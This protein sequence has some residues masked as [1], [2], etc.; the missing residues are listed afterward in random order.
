MLSEK[1]NSAKSFNAE[2]FVKAKFMFYSQVLFEINWVNQI[3]QDYLDDFHHELIPKTYQGG[4]KPTWFV[5]EMMEK[6]EREELRK[7][8]NEKGKFL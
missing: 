6:D 8:L 4:R 3:L 5:K 1:V 7:N 2:N